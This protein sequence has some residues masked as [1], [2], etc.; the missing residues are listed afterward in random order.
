ME[1]E[2]EELIRLEIKIN[3]LEERIYQLENN[4]M[5][6][7]FNIE[8]MIGEIEKLKTGPKKKLII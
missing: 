4:L 1:H 6:T 7:N 8:M 2:K 3:N 5:T